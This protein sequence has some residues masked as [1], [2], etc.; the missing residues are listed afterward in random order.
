[1]RMWERMEMERRDRLS[2]KLLAT[3]LVLNTPYLVILWAHLAGVRTST[4]ATVILWTIIPTAALM[5]MWYLMG[6]NT[7]ERDTTTH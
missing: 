5:G 3:L 6:V 4:I 2:I 1:M 7:N